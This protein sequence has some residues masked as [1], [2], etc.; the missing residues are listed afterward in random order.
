M[1]GCRRVCK[2]VEVKKVNRN[3]KSFLRERERNN[4]ETL[5]QIKEI[6]VLKH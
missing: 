6:I 5:N 4:L 2:G 3:V 1:K